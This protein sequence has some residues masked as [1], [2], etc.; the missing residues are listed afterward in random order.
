MKMGCR[1][2]NTG[3]QSDIT[4]KVSDDLQMQKAVQNT[5][6]YKIPV[7][8]LAKRT[9]FNRTAVILS[10]MTHHPD[11]HHLQCL[12]M[13]SASFGA[14]F[15]QTT[16]KK[17][18]SLLLR[19]SQVDAPI[20]VSPIDSFYEQLPISITDSCVRVER[21]CMESVGFLSRRSGRDPSSYYR[22]SAW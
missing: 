21:S 3:K 9:I 15:T 13:K 22:E 11:S 16:R 2:A 1:H 4:F 5:P 17:H 7:T 10:F 18:H 12:R 8:H 6:K 19:S 20:R 14:R